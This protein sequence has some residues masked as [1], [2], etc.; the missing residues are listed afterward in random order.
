MLWGHAEGMAAA[1]PDAHARRSP[2]MPKRYREIVRKPRRPVASLDAG[3]YLTTPRGKRRLDRL[4]A[5]LAVRPADAPDGGGAIRRL[6]APGA[7][8]AGYAVEGEP[9]AG[10]VLLRGTVPEQQ[11][12]QADPS[13][14][15]TLLEQARRLPELRAADPVYVDPE[16][17]LRLHPTG[18]MILCLR[19]GVDPS[20]YF[21]GHEGRVRPLPHTPD[22]FIMAAPGLTAEQLLADAN[23][24]NADSRVAWAEPNFALQVVECFTPN[25]PL[26]GQQ[27]HLR[28]TGQGGGLSGADVSAGAA[29]DITRGTNAIVIAVLDDGMDMEHPDLWANV[30]TNL[31]EI[32]NGVDDDGNGYV[33]DVHG[34]D[35][36]DG[37]N[38]PR[39]AAADD[40]HG[41]ST[42]GIAAAA[43]NDGV[44]VSG[45]APRCRILPLKVI[46]GDD[47]VTAATFAAALRYAAGLTASPTWR[48]AD[49]LSISLG[50]SRSSAI[51]SALAD[52]AHQGRQGKGCPIFATSGNDASA[53]GEYSL[54]DLP[55]GTYAFEW[56]YIKD[57]SLGA[58][59]DTCWLAN[60]R[61]PNGT[62]ERFDSPT[63]PAGWNVAPYEGVPWAIVDD[64][65]HAYG[66]GRYLAK[67]GTIGDSNTTDLR[68]P[69]NTLE[70]SGEVTF[71]YW[72][73][74][75][76]YDYLEFWVYEMGYGWSGPY[77]NDSGDYWY[78]TPVDYP[79]SHPDTFAVGAS[80]DFDYRADYS[81]YGTGLD[82]LAPSSGGA[83]WILT[84][85]RQGSAGA[86]PGNYLPEFGGT[87]ASCPL[88]AGIGALVLSVNPGLT[89]AEV[90]SILHATSDKVGR[91]NYLNGVNPY[92]GHGRVNA[93][94]ALQATPPPLRCAA[95]LL[96]PAALRL[97]LTGLPDAG[98]VILE[99]S[100]HLTAWIPWSTNT[101]T[102]STMDLVEPLPTTTPARFF[103][104]FIRAD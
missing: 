99:S 60:V 12:Q 21:R 71:H 65:A 39:P 90:R 17:N 100:T 86:D 43:G 6:T 19:A 61:F 22:Q 80:T 104:V 51:D 96:P 44:G 36:A 50:F 82:F 77:L 54:T 2:T 79:A 46:R 13:A 62:V 8:L 32:V 94:A 52:A 7:P 72:I 10:R 98:T 92:Y 28:N 101:I 103:R 53:Y 23:A 40:N 73:S 93:A 20:D 29:W 33:D 3:D 18:E 34:W 88:A 89:A 27:W 11:R 48:G 58:G 37:D 102:A 78:A 76:L 91:V 75:E 45:V 83:D 5:A 9:V 95:A 84:T 4:A 64:P 70:T 66:T 56:T 35:F 97:R 31:H 1:A 69:T 41:T 16:S 63:T 59:E 47:I 30:F 42:S 57:G 87:S 74:S 25:D 55:A 15:A 38:N 81:C 68:S 24:R 49:V 26:Y 67:A 14:L 85:D